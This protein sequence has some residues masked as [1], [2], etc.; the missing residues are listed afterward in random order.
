MFS[1][2][3]KII[4]LIFVQFLFSSFLF[5]QA[6]SLEKG[7]HLLGSDRDI[8]DM[9]KFK[10]VCA[11]NIYVYHTGKVSNWLT[12]PGDLTSIKKGQGFWI[13]IKKND[14]KI[15]TSPSEK[16]SSDGTNR[17]S[18]EKPS[19]NGTNGTS[20][21][22]S[23]NDGTMSIGTLNLNG[24]T[25]EYRFYKPD[26]LSNGAS[27]MFYFHGSRPINASLRVP[28]NLQDGLL[29]GANE[30]HI[31]NEL[32]RTDNIMIVY[33][34]STIR[35][36]G[37]GIKDASWSHSDT[38]VA[39]FDKLVEHFTSTYS[40]LGNSKIYVTGHSS[41]AIFSFKLAGERA[42]VIAGA[43]AVSSRFNLIKNGQLV[44]GVNFTNDGISTPLIA[45][46]GLND[47]KTQGMENSV[48]TWHTIENKGTLNDATKEAVTIGQ[49]STT[50]KTYKN[51]ISD[52][53]LYLIENE[54]HSVSWSAIGRVMWDFLKSHTR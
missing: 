3:K 12:Y 7:W 46:H 11:G 20:S 28:D 16:P 6:W 43:G 54:G 30:S 9:F 29:Q 23:S 2:Y 50:K 40:E 17:P 39:Y 19:K 44:N 36:Y 27:L 14:C 8:N 41:G 5:P 25:R 45:F 48:D 52:I 42:S 13:H 33:P 21:G 35:D 51:G 49:Y 4:T 24:V 26:S 10:P 47:I 1:I 38:E 37:G 15:S 18:S 22:E 34:L 53:E 31:F 32:A